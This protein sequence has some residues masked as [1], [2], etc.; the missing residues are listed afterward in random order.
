MML[1]SLKTDFF[2][3]AEIIYARIYHYDYST[4]NFNKSQSFSGKYLNQT[5]CFITKARGKFNFL[6][7]RI[8]Q[9][10]LMNLAWILPYN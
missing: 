3:C 5:G 4:V 1:M 2:T 9:A 7:F 6:L 8:N 10:F